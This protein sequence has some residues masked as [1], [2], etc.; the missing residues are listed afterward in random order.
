[1][2]GRAL[3]GG[4]GAPRLC[5]A[6]RAAAPRCPWMCSECG[7]GE[8]HAASEVPRLWGLLAGRQ[9]GLS[10]CAQCPGHLCGQRGCWA[11]GTGRRR[12]WF[13]SLGLSWH[14]G[15]GC[16]LRAQGRGGAG[17]RLPGAGDGARWC[18][19]DSLMG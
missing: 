3:P 9:E 4:F 19:R 6:T 13:E 10:R 14:P 11:G 17:V 8:L 15:D 12:M 16:G 7:R 5:T 18:L 2:D 1:M